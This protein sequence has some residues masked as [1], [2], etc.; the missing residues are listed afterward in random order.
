[1]FNPN[2]RIL[3]VGVE[4]ADNPGHY[5]PLEEVVEQIGQMDMD[6]E[7]RLGHQAGLIA[8][9]L[10]LDYLDQQLH[11]VYE[12]SLD[13][14][15]LAMFGC[16][17]TERIPLSPAAMDNAAA[18]QRAILFAR[19]LDYL[20]PEATYGR[21]EYSTLTSLIQDYIGRNLYSHFDGRAQFSHLI[22]EIVE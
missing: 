15:M 22:G 2:L 19:V 21:R 10:S 13:M 5:I 4:D 7:L 16:Y 20:K 1:P 14:G 6:A 8:A 9:Q 12:R 18:Y 17:I 3:L 11:P